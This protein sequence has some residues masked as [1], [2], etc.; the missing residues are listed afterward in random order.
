VHIGIAAL[1]VLVVADVR[2]DLRRADE[3][4]R[5]WST[6]RAVWVA[7]RPLAAGDPVPD[8]AEVRDIPEALLPDGTL[9]ADE[10][11]GA[12]VAGRAVAPGA[13]LTSLDLRGSG[14]APASVVPDDWLIV[15]V[16]TA[17]AA[18]VAPGDRVRVVAGGAV[19]SD[20]GVIVEPGSDDQPTLLA[21][22]AD[23]APLVASDLAGITLVLEQ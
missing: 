15:P 20:R 21:V 13:I 17:A 8:G 16:R 12:A 1:G 4:T 18:I 7:T 14:T 9:G 22:P 10:Q 19:L 23:A 5:S 11:L 2:S 3:T 6:T